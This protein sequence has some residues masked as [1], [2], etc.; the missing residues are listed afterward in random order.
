MKNLRIKTEKK[1]LKN[2]FIPYP[3]DIMQ[4]IKFWKNQTLTQCEDKGGSFNVQLYL[5]YLEIRYK[6]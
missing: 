2:V 6:S 4:C 5:D 1:E 3:K